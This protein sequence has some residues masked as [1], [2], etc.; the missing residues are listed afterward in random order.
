MEQGSARISFR[1]LKT[2]EIRAVPGTDPQF[3]AQV[4]SVLAGRNAAD[5]I[6][7][8]LV[9]KNRSKQAIIAYVVV[10]TVVDSSG[11][12]H[13]KERQYYNLYYY[14]DGV[15]NG[16]EIVPGTAQ[17]VTP[18]HSTPMPSAA[19]SAAGRN[20]ARTVTPRFDTEYPG[21][22]S[23][24][25]SL[26]LVVFADGRYIGPDENALSY[27]LRAQIDAEDAVA[28]LAGK[29]FDA[30]ADPVRVGEILTQLA[31]MDIRRRESGAASYAHWRD[32]FTIHIGRQLLFA[33]RDSTEDFQRS[34]T[35]I[36]SRPA[37]TLHR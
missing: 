14:L 30:S 23:V 13:L 9:L 37:I 22:C 12:T 34:I 27:S 17:I 33:I 7:Y 5:E 6:P 36:R 19:E 26:D 4:D 16:N 8:A 32:F 2:D 15:S 25:V 21:A 24:V 20:R 11:Q 35:R 10:A 29:E 28:E 1:L 18:Y 31:N 3:R